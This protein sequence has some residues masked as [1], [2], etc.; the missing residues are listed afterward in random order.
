[1]PRTVTAGTVARQI[2]SS[3]SRLFV[4]RHTSPRGS[5]ALTSFSQSVLFLLLSGPNL[6]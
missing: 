5:E 3:C 4:A 1:M 2:G 6:R